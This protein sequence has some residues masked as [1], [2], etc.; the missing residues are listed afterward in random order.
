EEVAELK[1]EEPVKEAEAQTEQ[2]TPAQEAAPAAPA[3]KKP[4]IFTNL[5]G[6]FNA[7]STKSKALCCGICAVI[8]L[9]I[10]AICCLA[11]GK[12]DYRVNKDAIELVLDSD[13]DAYFVY[14]GKGQHKKVAGAEKNLS[15]V[16]ASPDGKSYVVKDDESNYYILT[17]KGMT[18]FAEEGAKFIFSANSNAVAYIAE[19]KKETQALFVYDIKSKKTTEVASPVAGKFIISANGKHVCYIDEDGDEP[20]AYLVKNLKNKTKLGKNV[21]PIAVSDNGKLVYYTDI[22]TDKK[23]GSTSVTLNLLKGSKRT[24]IARD[25]SGGRIVFNKN[26]TQILFSNDDKVRLSVNGK[27]P[28]GLTKGTLSGIALNAYTVTQSTRTGFTVEIVYK[29]TLKGALLVNSENVYYIKNLKTAEKVINGEN[30]SSLA[31]SYDYKSLLYIKDDNVYY[32]SNIK[33]PDKVKKVA[34]LEDYDVSNF[35]ASKDLKSFYFESDDNLYFA[36]RGG[37]VKLIAEEVT[38]VGYDYLTD[39]IYYFK[40]YSNG[41]VADLYGS[42]GGRK[43]KKVAKKALEVDTT[44]GDVP[45]VYRE[46]KN[47]DYADIYILNGYS[48]KNVKVKVE[49][50]SA[51]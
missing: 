16:I 15:R 25:F 7:L 26:L 34:D 30:I 23:D 46:N 31:V 27:D 24:V 18:K 3:E 44:R 4:N 38:T 11:G 19:N 8:V 48:I 35:T 49:G 43:N 45:I 10:I 12:K 50:A 36:K 17:I 51:R 13:A 9:A 37:K 22:T 21:T 5:I 1:A 6:K 32:M 42:K 2:A 39:T 41:D 40:D 29:N 47:D 14:N 20:I 28:A 33:N